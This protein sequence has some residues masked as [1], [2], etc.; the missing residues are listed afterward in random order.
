[1]RDMNSGSGMQWIDKPQKLPS[2]FWEG[3]WN[4]A[5]D[6]RFEVKTAGS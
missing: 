5:D 1:M 4:R 3:F 2:A 6:P